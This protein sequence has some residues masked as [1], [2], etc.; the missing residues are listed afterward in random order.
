L[1]PLAAGVELP[2]FGMQVITAP[3]LR[4]DVMRPDKAIEHQQARRQAGDSFLRFP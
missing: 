3:C 2:E 4:V 1:C